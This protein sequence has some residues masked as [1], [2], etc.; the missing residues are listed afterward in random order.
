MTDRALILRIVEDARFAPTVHNIQPSVYR[1]APDGSVTLGQ[2]PGRNLPVGDP[3]GRDVAASHGSAAEGFVLAAGALGYAVTVEAGTGGVATLRLSKGGRAD[4]LASFLRTRRTYRGV[5]E[6]ADAADIAALITAAPDLTLLTSAQ[7]I[8]AVAKLN[9]EASL[10]TFRDTGFRAELLSWMRLKKG[11]PRWARDG[12]NAQAMG[13]SGI[14]AAGAGFA[15]RPGVFEVL[16]KLGLA[17]AL[18]GEAATVKTASAVG[19]FCRPHGEAPFETGRRWHRL[20]LEIERLG[21]SAAPMTVLADDAKACR[22]LTE[23]Y[24][25]EDHLVTVF[26]IGVAPHDGKALPARLPA[27]ELVTGA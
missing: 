26:R 9:D 25:L 19:L 11:H 20:W 8:A 27:E 3:T 15:L 13:M 1:L 7:D 22:A 17:G 10:R 6:P 23:T 21:L 4:E 24:G 12:L 2:A 14:E 16:D 5:F 18:T